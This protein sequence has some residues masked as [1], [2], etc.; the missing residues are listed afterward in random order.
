M[1]SMKKPCPPWLSLPWKVGSRTE[2]GVARSIQTDSW[3]N[4]VEAEVEIPSKQVTKKDIW[5]M[6]ILLWVKLDRFVFGIKTRASSPGWSS[7]RHPE[8]YLTMEM[9]LGGFGSTCE[10]WVSRKG[11]RR[12]RLLI[13]DILGIIFCWLQVFSS[14]CDMHFHNMLITFWDG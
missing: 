2:P 4:P 14:M 10:K 11:K 13:Q 6:S 9:L 7:R 5:L 8:N 12:R 3:H 1:E